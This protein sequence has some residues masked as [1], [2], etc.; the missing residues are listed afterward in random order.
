MW[1][2]IERRKRS[3]IIQEDVRL[4][5]LLVRFR[6]DPELPYL[7]NGGGSSIESRTVEL[8]ILLWYPTIQHRVLNFFLPYPLMWINIERH[9][10]SK[11]NSDQQIQHCKWLNHR[12]VILFSFCDEHY[13][14]TATS[15]QRLSNHITGN[16]KLSSWDYFWIFLFFH[17]NL[18]ES[19]FRL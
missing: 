17:M 19:C 13:D 1:I 11:W 7:A 6:I 3:E 15:T 8:K 5:W 9:W 4:E 14:V 16:P 18:K 2:N 12:H 10:A